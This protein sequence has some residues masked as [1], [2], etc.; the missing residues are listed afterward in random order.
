MRQLSPR[1][2]RLT[3]PR[4]LTPRMAAKVATSKLQFPIDPSSR[5]SRATSSLARAPS[6][7]ASS[8]SSSLSSAAP[9]PETEKSTLTVNTYTT[10]S[11]VPSFDA[12]TLSRPPLEAEYSDAGLPRPAWPAVPFAKLAGD[13]PGS[14]NSIHEYFRQAT[15]D[16]PIS[17][18]TLSRMRMS[19]PANVSDMA[20]TKAPRRPNRPPSP[21]LS[22]PSFPPYQRQYS[23]SPELLRSPGG[24]GSPGAPPTPDKS[25]R[26]KPRSGSISLKGLKHMSSRNFGWKRGE[27]EKPPALPL[28]A[29]NEMQ[30]GLPGERPAGMAIGLFGSGDGDRDGVKVSPQASTFPGLGMGQPTEFGQNEGASGVSRTGSVP[31][32]TKESGGFSRWNPFGSRRG[33]GNTGTP[34]SPAEKEK[35]KNRSSTKSSKRNPSIDHKSIGPP[36]SG[37]FQRNQQPTHGQSASISSVRSVSVSHSQSRPSLPGM[38]SSAT[39]HTL[40]SEPAEE[41]VSPSMRGYSSS[42]GHEMSP[43]SVKRKPVPL[44]LGQ[45]GLKSSESIGS[46]V[47]V[48]D[49]RVNRGTWMGIPIGEPVV[50][51][52]A[53]AAAAV[54][55]EKGMK[56]SGSVKSLGKKGKGEVPTP[57]RLGRRGTGD[58]DEKPVVPQGR[59]IWMGV[60]VG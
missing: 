9:I 34:G 16:S 35:D 32:K 40:A 54:S 51:D 49:K 7:S 23:L 4:M 38:S 20:G 6:H 50:V 3:S 57:P 25:A 1:D 43:R 27:N 53:A 55:P 22:D 18:E 11:S 48:T 14:P 56:K 45:G 17:T 12:T 59:G 47:D 60:Q 13:S 21:D 41:P 52:I 29:R 39:T 28:M 15:P 10:Q 46:M 8:S 37:T 24:P 33:N 42:H 36:I 5:P 58:S 30:P 44:P 26:S 2:I 31:S 19:P